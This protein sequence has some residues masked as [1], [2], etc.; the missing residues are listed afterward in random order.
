[1]L[2]VVDVALALKLA[3]TDTENL[4]TAVGASSLSRRSLVLERDGLGVLNIYFFPAFHAIRLHFLASLVV[5]S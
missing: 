3:L 1:M 4:G 2:Y 5:L